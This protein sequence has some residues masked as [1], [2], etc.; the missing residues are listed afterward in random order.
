MNRTF[1]IFLMVGTAMMIAVIGQHEPDVQL[2]YLPWEIE[3]L[4]NGKSSAFGI[5]L[6]K[7]T[8]QEANQIFANF[9]ATR[10]IVDTSDEKQQQLRLVA[11]YNDLVIGGLIAQLELDY[12]L[13]QAELKQLHNSLS[14]ENTISSS[15]GITVMKIP[16]EVE[17][18]YLNTAVNRIT[19]IPSIKL[20]SELLLQ[21]FG[22]MANETTEK[23]GS[24]RWSYPALGLDIYQ[25]E[26]KLERFVYSPLK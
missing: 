16:S 7:T 20:G 11:L 18:N 21:R 24:L 26:N 5:T 6:E 22:P 13:S 14:A 4:E 1:L 23:D 25:H 17:M 10:L 12:Q 15:A 19:Y 8:V 2:D 3:I 9:A